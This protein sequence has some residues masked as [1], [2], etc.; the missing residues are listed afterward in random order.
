MYI[1]KFIVSN[2]WFFALVISP[3]LAG[4]CASF[5]CSF[6]S[7]TAITQCNGTVNGALTF[8]I[9]VNGLGANF[10]GTVD[11]KFAGQIFD[12]PAGSLSLWLK[13]NSSDQKGG[14]TEI[15]RLGGV[16][17]HRG[18]LDWLEVG[19]TDYQVLCAL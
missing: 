14:I 7:E 9:A 10:N 8:P 16:F 17:L 4:E 1:N 19:S 6:D 15:G 13:K 11:V 12:T 3:S 5:Y 18:V 2:L